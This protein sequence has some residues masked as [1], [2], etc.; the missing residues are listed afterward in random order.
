MGANSR[1]A[2]WAIFVL[3]YAVMVSAAPERTAYIKRNPLNLAVIVLSYPG[4]PAIFGL[5][6]LARLARF[7]RL[8]SS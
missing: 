7:L 4:L 5:V 3:E 2:V 8:L 1:L 6:R